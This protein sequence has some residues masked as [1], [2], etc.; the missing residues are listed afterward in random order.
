MPGLV[1]SETLNACTSSLTP[2]TDLQ[3][4]IKDDLLTLLILLQIRNTLLIISTL[5]EHLWS[6]LELRNCLQHVDTVNIRHCAAH[7]V[8]HLAWDRHRD[9]D[10]LLGSQ[11]PAPRGG[12]AAP[13]W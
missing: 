11:G 4:L 10:T 5:L 8:G 6:A 9:L 2:T 1:S 12:L 7:R 3:A 13:G